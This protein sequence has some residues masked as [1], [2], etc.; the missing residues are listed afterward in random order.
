MRSNCRSSAPSTASRPERRSQDKRRSVMSRMQNILEKAEREGAVMRV[1]SRPEPAGVVP[2]PAA[3]DA[4]VGTLPVAGRRRTRR[5]HVASHSPEQFA[6]RR[7]RDRECRRRAVP[8]PL[9]SNRSRRSE[10]HRER[11]PHHQPRLRRRQEHHRRQCRAHDSARVPAADVH[12]RCEPAIP[13]AE[14]AVRASRRSGS[15][16]RPRRTCAAQRGA[17]DDR[18]PRPDRAAS[19]PLP[20]ASG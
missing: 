15:L 6:R 8:G 1:R 13:E 4:G 18:N 11:H 17:H 5:P 9:H 19:R 14:G 7:R 20:A 10:R 12:R 2:A 3:L 16:G